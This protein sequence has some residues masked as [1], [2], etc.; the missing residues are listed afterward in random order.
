LDLQQLKRVLLAAH[1]EKEVVMKRMVPFNLWSK[2]CGS[3]DVRTMLRQPAALLQHLQQQCAARTAADYLS[4]VCI[5]LQ[6]PAVAALLPPDELARALRQLL[7]ARRQHGGHVIAQYRARKAQKASEQ[8]PLQSQAAAAVA[9]P[10]LVRYWLPAA[11]Q[12]QLSIA[13]LVSQRNATAADVAAQAGKTHGSSGTDVPA[14]APALSGAAPS[15][16]ASPALGAASLQPAQGCKQHTA[17]KSGGSGAAAAAAAAVPTTAGISSSF[18][19]PAADSSRQHQQHQQHQHQQDADADVQQCCSTQQETGHAASLDLQ[20][21]RQLLGAAWSDEGSHA[22]SLAMWPFKVWS[23]ACGSSDVRVLL[24]QPAVLLQQLQQ[25]LS[26][27]AAAVF[28]EQVCAVLQLPTIAA[29]LHKP[30]LASLKQQLTDARQDSEPGCRTESQRPAAKRREPDSSVDVGKVQAKK[31]RSSPAASCSAL[32]AAADDHERDVGVT[33]VDEMSPRSGSSGTDDD[34]APAVGASEAAAMHAAAEAIQALKQQ[35]QRQRQQQ[36]Y[37]QQQ[38][39][40]HRLPSGAMD[41]EQLQQLLLDAWSDADSTSA[42]TVVTL[43]RLWAAAAGS[44]NVATLLRQPQALLGLLQQQTFTAATV[45]GYVGSVERVLTLPAVAAL[46]S[47]TEMASLLQQLQEAKQG[48][49]HDPSHPCVGDAAAPVV[50]ISSHEAA[51]S[52]QPWQQEHGGSPATIQQQRQQQQQRRQQEQQRRRQQQQEQQWR[53]QQ[54]LQ[55]KQ[56]RQRQRQREQQ[57]WQ[58]QLEQQ[59]MPGVPA[60]SVQRLKID[61]QATYEPS[62]ATQITI[63]INVW[64]EACKSDDVCS[65]LLQPQPLLQKLREFYTPRCAVRYLDWVHEALALPE[66]AALLSTERMASLQ[67]QL[68]YARHEFMQEDL[69]AAAPASNEAA[70]R[71]LQQQQQQQAEAMSRLDLQQLQQVLLAAHQDKEAVRKRMTPFNVWS[72]ACGSSYVCTMLRQPAALLQHLQQQCTPGTAA[73]YLNRVH[74]V[75]QLPAF[76]ALLP[77]DELASL[78]QQLRKA[79]QHHG[80]H[81]KAQ[82]KAV[83]AHEASEEPPLLSASPAAAA[84]A[85]TAPSQFQN[86]LPTA[87]QC[88]AAAAVPRQR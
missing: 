32:P 28:L 73:M 34:A 72:K 41:I 50:A 29:L 10:S 30:E 77:P 62:R 53:Q 81:A 71:Q 39:Q 21:L 4:R 63:P 1:Q 9:A 49:M 87:V 85:V 68:G 35:H 31:H 54:N 56:Q 6:L 14:A 44:S 70:T 37:Q 22:V 46:L 23:Q 24:Q 47:T 7:E 75:L 74:I 40:L 20:Q 84:A 76:A 16:V 59:R 64:S 52:Q 82:Y 17:D 55:R 61:L 26:V 15:T 3:S 79:E 60:L 58:Q 11:A 51:T 45:A 88:N 36:H 38:Q 19:K 5:V 43:F 33:G 48:T 2:A 27:S 18:R 12:H 8:P 65:L 78:L 66:V 57:Q 42:A 13:Q 67:Q 80:R 86:W 83:K 25:R 69:A